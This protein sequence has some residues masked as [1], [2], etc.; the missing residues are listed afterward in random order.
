[1]VCGVLCNTLSSNTSVLAIA[2]Y[3]HPL[4]NETPLTITKKYLLQQRKAI[5]YAGNS[6]AGQ[7][8]LAPVPAMVWTWKRSRRCASLMGPPT[9]E[10]AK[11]NNMIV[12]CTSPLFVT[13]LLRI[14]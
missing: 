7:Y 9:Q 13:W 6:S 2:I 11:S 10:L 1:M 3:T 5:T 12:E 8:I 14:T 4:W